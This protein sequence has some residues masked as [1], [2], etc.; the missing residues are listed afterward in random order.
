MEYGAPKVQN[1]KTGVAC[2]RAV[3]L[4]ISLT[5]CSL[6]NAGPEEIE[7]EIKITGRNRC[8]KILDIQSWP[9]F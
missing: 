1:W 8:I 6:K 2:L 9:R 5:E 3:S 4:F 7:I